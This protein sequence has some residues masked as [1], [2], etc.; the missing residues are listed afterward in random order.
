MANINDDPQV[1][2]DMTNKVLKVF[3]EWAKKQINMQDATEKRFLEEIRKHLGMGGQISGLEMTRQEY[4]E[5]KEILKQK[6]I[7]YSGLPSSDSKI[8]LICKKE[9]TDYVQDVINAYKQN[10]PLFAKR[11]TVNEVAKSCDLLEESTAWTITPNYM[12]NPNDSI[13]EIIKSNLYDCNITA[14]DTHEK[15]FLPGGDGLSF[16]KTGNDI[17]KFHLKMAVKNAVNFRNEGF[18]ER[19]VDYNETYAQQKAYDVMTIKEFVERAKAGESIVLCNT[20]DKSAPAVRAIDGVISYADVANEGRMYSLDTKDLPIDTIEAHL[21]TFTDEHIYNKGILPLN[22]YKTTPK[23][24]PDVAKEYCKRPILDNELQ[25]IKLSEDALKAVFEEVNEVATKRAKAMFPNSN[26]YAE[27]SAVKR[28]AIMDILEKK[29][30]TCIKEY[31][32]SEAIVKDENGKP[33]LNED[34]SYQYIIKSK[35][36]LDDQLHD[37]LFEAAVKCYKDHN[38]N[39][40]SY[41]Q[42]SVSEIRN[43]TEKGFD[44]A[45]N[46]MANLAKNLGLNE[47]KAKMSQAE[48]ELDTAKKKLDRAKMSV[49]DQKVR[50]VKAKEEFD[51]KIDEVIAPFKSEAREILKNNLASGKSI[52][53]QLGNP[54][55]KEF[56]DKAKAV[57]DAYDA[58]VKAIES[59]DYNVDEFE[60][61]VSEKE[62]I[63]KAA[64]SDYERANAEFNSQLTTYQLEKAQKEESIHNTVEFD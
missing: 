46:Y 27:L 3:E 1:L 58:E 8:F 45:K 55:T 42:T 52:S 57:E 2:L 54:A 63:Y 20:F 43:Y 32:K 17:E 11:M 36:G 13:D 26:N 61:E 38:S 64:S 16:N 49:A 7:P 48:I 56:A 4:E 53:S 37:H 39:L 47:K 44:Y 34:G 6:D 12:S 31:L 29:E 35:D 50:L 23:F 40:Y 24:G 30:L 14:S 41:T 28:Q 22:V 33:V 60:A 10:D 19:G 51:K 21:K 59:E 15:M 18:F 9:D 25:Q 62:N 5:I